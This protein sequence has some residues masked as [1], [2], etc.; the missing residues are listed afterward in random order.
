MTHTTRYY[1]QHA[2]T[3]FQST[4]DVDMGPLH[5]KFLAHVPPGGRILDAGCGSGRDAKA[6]KDRGHEVD[7]FDASAELARLASE[8]LGQTVAVHT[9]LELDAHAVYD[10]V[11][12]CASLLH[13]PLADQPAAW[14]RLWQALR[15]G[16]V[17][18]ASYKLGQGCRVDDTSR[19][20][21]DANE[22]LVSDWLGGQADVQQL[23][24]WISPDQRGGA[25]PDWLNVLSIRQ[26]TQA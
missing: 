15:P 18:Y 4:V 2:T 25:R 16:G 11:W 20:F 1:N 23:T 14:A 10:G 12:A 5:A 9:F 22:T 13:V 7:A 19:A 3:F 17:V 6:F 21:T 24:S 8:H 26:A